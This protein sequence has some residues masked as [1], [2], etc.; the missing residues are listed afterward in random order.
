MEGFQ[1]TK[2]ISSE[3]FEKTIYTKDRKLIMLVILMF[4]MMIV[5]R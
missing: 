5:M 1:S 3:T 2:Y 4:L